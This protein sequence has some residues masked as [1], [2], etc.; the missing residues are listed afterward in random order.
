MESW[1]IWT[2]EFK[3]KLIVHKNRGHVWH[4]PNTVFQEKNQLWSRE[5]SQVTFAEGGWGKSNTILKKITIEAKLDPETWQW[6]KIYQWNHKG[7]AMESS[8]LCQSLDLYLSE[9][10]QDDLKWAEDG[11]NPNISQLKWVVRQTYHN[12]KSETGRWFQNVLLM[13]HT[14]NLSWSIFLFMC[15]VWC[16]KQCIF[17]FIICTYIIFYSTNF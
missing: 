12:P 15:F 3:R 10:Q 8:R 5:H 14:L 13:F 4:K 16:V 1:I 7:K 17:L 11:R 2:E 9:L 6:P